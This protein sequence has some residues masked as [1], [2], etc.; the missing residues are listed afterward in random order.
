MRHCQVC[1]RNR[2]GI[3]D[4]LPPQA[5]NAGCTHGRSSLCGV[6]RGCQGIKLCI[7]AS[8]AARQL[9]PVLEQPS[10]P[11]VGSYADRHSRG[12]SSSRHLSDAL[13][14]EAV[15]LQ[16]LAQVRWEALST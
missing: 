15:V 3:T 16:F 6:Q 8:R 13:A 5:F 14:Q 11:M 4:S 7:S 2:A 12:I 9:R 10:I 1:I